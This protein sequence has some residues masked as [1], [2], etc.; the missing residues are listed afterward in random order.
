MDTDHARRRSTIS[1]AARIAVRIFKGNDWT[2]AQTLG[3]W[4]NESEIAIT[5]DKLLRDIEDHGATSVRGGRLAAERI[6]EE[7]GTPTGVRFVLELGQF[8]Y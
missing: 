5:L 3:R 6:T 1:A 8:D 2:W 4:P 7:D